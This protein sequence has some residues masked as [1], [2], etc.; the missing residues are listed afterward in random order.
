MKKILILCLIIFTCHNVWSQ[1]TVNAYKYVVVPL[2][3]DFLKGQNVHRLNTLTKVLFKQHGFDVHF[4]KSDLPQDLFEDRCLAM[5]ADVHKVRGGFRKTRLEI[6]LKDCHGELIFT[7]EMGQSGE[8]NH[9]K[10]HQIALR[11]SFKSIKKLNYKYQPKQ[12]NTANVA[13]SK[14]NEKGKET[15]KAKLETIEKIESI[16]KAVNTK[17]KNVSKKEKEKL[18]ETQIANE[19]AAPKEI[20]N[21]LYATPIKN[22]YQIQDE[23]KKDVMILLKTAAKNV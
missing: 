14:E 11:E 18:V 7:S 2:Q 20:S 13:V 22:G 17:I 8:N 23:A 9:E 1:S 16:E 4:E 6:T 21:V 12:A 3:Y 15:E 10:R 19:Q 5:Y